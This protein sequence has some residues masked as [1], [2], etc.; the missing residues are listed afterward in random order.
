MDARPGARLQVLLGLLWI[1]RRF[2]GDRWSGVGGM[3]LTKK[4]GVSEIMKG[5][6]CL[7]KSE[8]WLRYPCSNVTF[9]LCNLI[10]IL[11]ISR[12]ELMLGLLYRSINSLP[13]SVENGWVKRSKKSWLNCL[14]KIINLTST[15]SWMTRHSPAMLLFYITDIQT[16]NKQ[17]LIAASLQAKTL[18]LIYDKN[19]PVYIELPKWV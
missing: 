16:D 9:C 8:G 1:W 19:Q 11:F 4:R 13:I 17:S 5:I 3:N 14:E 18:V 10:Y 12:N 6:N 2:L 7:E 15:P